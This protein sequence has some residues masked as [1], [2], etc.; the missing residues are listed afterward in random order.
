MAMN[1]KI[2]GCSR[3]RP[4]ATMAEKVLLQVSHIHEQRA[5][6]RTHRP[7]QTRR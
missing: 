6:G 7:P 1:T 5:A 3:M 2:I 4:T